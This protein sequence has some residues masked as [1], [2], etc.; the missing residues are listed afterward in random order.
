MMDS[1]FD[2]LPHCLIY[3]DDFLVLSD[4]NMEHELHFGEV[5]SILRENGLIVRSNKYTFAAPTEDFLG[6]RI[7]SDGIRQ[8]Q[9]KVKAIQDYSVPTTINEIQAFIS[10]AADHMAPLYTNLSGNIRT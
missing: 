9:S 6:H 10:M 8:L 1:I 3:M 4:N 2:Q 5:L 7:S